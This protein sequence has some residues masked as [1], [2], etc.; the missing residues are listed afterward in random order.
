LKLQNA[1]PQVVAIDDHPG[2]LLALE[3]AL[4][5]LNCDIK[6]FTNPLEALAFIESH[7]VA[8]VLLDIRMP[9]LDGFEAAQRIRQIPW[10]KETPIIFVSGAEVSDSEIGELERV[11]GFTV[12]QKPINPRILLPKLR[13][14]I[15][16]FLKTQELEAS[17]EEEKTLLLDEAL[18]AIVGINDKNKIIYWNKNAENIF[19]WQKEEALG[20]DL[21]IIIPER[22]RR[23]HLAGLNRLISTGTQRILNQRLEIPAVRKSG[24]EF[25]IELTVTSIQSSKGYNFFAFMRDISAQKQAQLQLE[26]AGKRATLLASLSRSLHSSLEVEKILT[27]LS[28]VTVPELADWC[29]IQMLD[30][31]GRLRQVAVSHKDPEKVKWAWELH[32]RFPPDP[33][34][35]YGP[36]QVIRAGKPE[37]MKE[38]SEAMIVNSIKSK[39]QR[40]VVRSLG[41]RSYICVPIINRGRC[42]GTLSLVMTAESERI[43]A[44]EDLEFALELGIR[45]GIAIENARLYREAQVSNRLKDEFLANLSH[46]LRTP[47]NV[48]LGYAG[49]LKE[50]GATLSPEDFKAFIDAIERNA[51]AQEH[52]ISDLLDVS[53][54][55]TGKV[56]FDPK[57]IVLKDFLE[58]ALIGFH[59]TADGKGVK[60]VSDLSEARM[61]VLADPTRLQQIIWN[62]LSNAVKFTKAGGT[63]EVKVRRSPTDWSI[64]ISDSGIG[65]EK[66]FLPYVFERFRQE[67][68]STTR[69]YGGL[70][71][72]LS[73]VKNLAELHGGSV[74]ADSDGRGQGATFTVTFPLESLSSSSKNDPQN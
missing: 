37:L 56:S 44:E 43:Y 42:F 70:G 35:T 26:K 12:I 57:P 68:A 2:N 74:K 19:G 46:E 30:S 24:A 8:A 13:F 64:S 61:T 52:I 67:D 69:R 9:I 20:Q 6:S 51:R 65:I 62:L 60:L 25:L 29:S 21:L 49:I 11:G 73:V 15:D 18:D 48:I 71:L 39:E 55:I 38:V 17:L 23:Q 34:L 3:A 58:K 14:F 36:Y 1:K 27:S 54:I 7:R 59:P 63:V 22:M 10:T 32:S 53:A 40:E 4:S 5:E 66:D 16:L 47:M 28:D 41:L 31:Q 33:D 45:A 50:E 72:G